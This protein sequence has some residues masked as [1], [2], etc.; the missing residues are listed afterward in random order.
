LRSNICQKLWIVDSPNLQRL[1][2]A[3]IINKKSHEIWDYSDHRKKARLLTVSEL[4]SGAWLKALP[5]SNL[6][7]LLDSPKWPP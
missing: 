4:E 5:S 7:T 6:D 2:D 3:Q 1:W